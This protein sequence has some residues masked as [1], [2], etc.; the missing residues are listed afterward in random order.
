MRTG[1]S[2]D[3]PLRFPGQEDNGGPESYNIFRWYR[4]SWGRYT[5]ADLI[6][7]NGGANLY[8][9]AID[10]PLNFFDPRGLSVV[11]DSSGIIHGVDQGELDSR[12]HMRGGGVSGG[13]CTPM[14]Y[15]TA[16]CSCSCQ[17]P[18]WKPDT[19]ATIHF[20]MYIFDGN[21][22]QF[23][24]GRQPRDRSV[25][26][27]KSAVAHEFGWHQDP[28]SM[29]T[30]TSPPRRRSGCESA[31][32]A[33]ALRLGQSARGLASSL[34][35]VPMFRRSERELGAAHDRGHSAEHHSGFQRHGLA[36]A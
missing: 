1:S 16:T 23:L 9:Y 33:L 14:L 27:Y 5:Q 8:R 26:D 12:C 34:P 21:W 10:N 31:R 13:G 28:T 29:P 35:A 30:R 2:S 22:P 20:E 6:G 3:Q 17:G 11:Q 25:H 15:A 7:L 32:H 24:R 18:S 4:S 36:V 19:I